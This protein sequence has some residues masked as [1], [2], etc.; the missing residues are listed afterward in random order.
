MAWENFQEMLEQGTEIEVT[1]EAAVKGGVTTTLDGVRAF[2]PASQLSA[3][4]VENLEEF[5]GKTIKTKVITADPEKKRLVLSGRDAARAA[6]REARK[7]ARAARIAALVPGTVLTGTVETI[8][9]Y[10]A[11]VA[12]GD[13]I[14]GLVHV[15][16]I[17]TKR[18]KTPDEVLTVGDEVQVKILNTNNGKVSLSMKA[19]AEPAAPVEE[20]PAEEKINIADYVSK[21]KATTNLG[22]LL[23]GIKL[24]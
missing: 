3:G 16:Q 8:Q 13:G 20:K 23:K 18:I 15:S 10:G 12:L 1:V 22:S 2:I 24:N 14:S 11:F 7:A 21:E 19:L 5:V 6:A 17:S 9:P 4:Y